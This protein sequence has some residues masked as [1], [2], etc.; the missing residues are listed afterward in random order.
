MKT[1]FVLYYVIFHARLIST[2]TYSGQREPSKT[3]VTNIFEKSLVL[4]IE[5]VPNIETKLV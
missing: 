5:E 2:C 3:L 1:L 4:Y